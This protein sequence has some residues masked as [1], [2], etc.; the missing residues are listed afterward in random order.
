MDGAPVKG[1][2]EEKETWR[3][4]RKRGGRREEG[5]RREAREWEDLILIF[6]SG[7]NSR[8]RASWRLSTYSYVQKYSRE[9]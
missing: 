2:E 6:V 9:I 5:G 1:M 7:A 4:G 8:A 3:I